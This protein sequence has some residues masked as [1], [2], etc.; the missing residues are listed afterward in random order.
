VAHGILLGDDL[1]VRCHK[2]A[3][4]ERQDVDKLHLPPLPI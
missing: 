1:A 4:S 3:V 2:A